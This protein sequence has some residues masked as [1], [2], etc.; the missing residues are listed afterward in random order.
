MPFLYTMIHFINIVKQRSTKKRNLGKC[1][2]H[3]SVVSLRSGQVFLFLLIKNMP[4]TVVYNYCFA[5]TSIFL[6]RQ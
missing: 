2:I 5:L 1:T 6:L 3:L 4:V